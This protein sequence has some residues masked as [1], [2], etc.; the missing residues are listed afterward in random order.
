[1]R[2]GTCLLLLALLTAGCSRAF[3]RRSADRETYQAIGQHTNEAQWPVS[4]ISIEP[5]S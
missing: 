2:R 4:N 3:Y 1:M 5:P